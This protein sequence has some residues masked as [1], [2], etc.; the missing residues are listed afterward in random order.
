MKNKIIVVIIILFCICII[1]GVVFFLNRNNIEVQNINDNQIENTITNTTQENYINTINIESENKLISNIQVII[2]GKTYNSKL[3]ENKTAQAFVNMLPVEYD[4]NE[5]NGNEKY[6]YLSNSLP[7]NSYSP[8]HIEAGDIMLYGNNC[9]V[10]FYKSFDTSYSYTKIGHIEN[11][12]DLGNE[13][14]TIKFEL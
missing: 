12:S 11:L 13:N 10:V 4:M 8:K 1:G 5:L 2:N 7:T 14:I 6:V 9:L 3:E